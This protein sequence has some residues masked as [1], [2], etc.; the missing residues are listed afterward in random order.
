MR[1]FSESL[2]RAE[3]AYVG[4]NLLLRGGY[5]KT[6]FQADQTTLQSVSQL[7]ELAEGQPKVLAFGEYAT[8]EPRFAR[9]K[10][11]ANAPEITRFRETI[12]Q[13]AIKRHLVSEFN[14]RNLFTGISFD[15]V[16]AAELEVLGEK[17]IPQGHI[18]ILLKQRVPVGSDPKIPIEVKTK[19]ALPKDLSQLRAY[20]NELR[21][22]CP[23]GMLIA[24]DFHKQVI[25]SARN[26]NIR[27]VRYSL[28]ERVGEAPTFEELHQS[29]KLEPI[30][31]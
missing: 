10:G 4:E 26:F 20:M 29:L 7:G 14:L 18:D 6:H 11:L 9:V 22:E 2:I 13:S 24:N 28:S 21:G 1:A 27:L 19:K 25:Q 31:V 3:F 16:P 5:S 30:P 8:F 15:A 12:L 17:A 23:I